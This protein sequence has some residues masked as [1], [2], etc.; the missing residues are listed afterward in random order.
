MSK[1]TTSP[2][3]LHWILVRQVL[4]S[5]PSR[6]PTSRSGSASAQSGV[7]A[8]KP[9]STLKPL[10]K[11]AQHFLQQQISNHPV[12]IRHPDTQEWVRVAPGELPPELTR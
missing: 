4:N 9:P 3:S 2:Y 1:Q 6:F 10:L 12:Y 5:R 7:V 11:R 8:P